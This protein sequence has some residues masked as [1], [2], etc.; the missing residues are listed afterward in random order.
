MRFYGLIEKYELKITLTCTVTT[1]DSRHS[2]V[3]GLCRRGISWPE[4]LLH[5]RGVS[6]EFLFFREAENLSLGTL[7][8]AAECASLSLL[9]ADCL[10]RSDEEILM[11]TGYPFDL[12][13]EPALRSTSQGEADSFERD[14]LAFLLF[15]S[16]HSPTYL[17]LGIYQQI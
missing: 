17:P 11:G 13:L 5:D 10:P 9:R 8:H 1:S 7:L 4:L 15:L 14:L 16:V 6:F 2:T 3:F 12:C